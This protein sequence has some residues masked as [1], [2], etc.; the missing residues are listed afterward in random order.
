MAKEV[1]TRSDVSGETGAETWSITDQDGNR[2]LVD[3][4][5]KDR[6]K[7]LDEVL[8]HARPDPA[9]HDGTVPG[10]SLESR[11]RGVPDPS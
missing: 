6:K 3:L 2:W 11:I 5:E 1:V 8:S 10:R 9:S 7:S 4:V